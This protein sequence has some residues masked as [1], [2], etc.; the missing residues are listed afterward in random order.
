[1][2]TTPAIDQQIYHQRLQRIKANNE[3]LHSITESVQFL[4]KLGLPLR[5]H[6]DNIKAN[7][8]L[9]KGKLIEPLNFRANSDDKLLANMETCKK[10]A[11]YSSKTFN[12]LA[13][14]NHMKEST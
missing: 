2:T 11:R 1:M 5:G 3:M 4:G 7:S 13:L 14:R 12:I 10:N 8:T 6:R 9:N